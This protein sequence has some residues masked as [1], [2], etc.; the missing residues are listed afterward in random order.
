MS[1]HDDDDDDCPGCG[2]RD[3]GFE[4]PDVRST[5]RIPACRCKTSCVC[6]PE[7]KADAFDK[8]EAEPGCICEDLGCD[9]ED[10]KI[11]VKINR[12]WDQTCGHCDGADWRPEFQVLLNGKVVATVPSEEAADA[13]IQA[14]YPSAE[15]PEPDWAW[16]SEKWLRR[17]E[18]WG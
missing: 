9:C 15:A 14:E 3:L 4:L 8:F 12:I 7:E 2:R 11:E 5:L 1:Y 13:V 17:A 6:T 16:E 18:G 10:D